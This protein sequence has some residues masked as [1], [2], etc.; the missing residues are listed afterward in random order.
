MN[1]NNLAVHILGFAALLGVV[2]VWS[3]WVIASRWGLLQSP[4][5]PMELMLLRFVFA[6]AV[7]I[8]VLLR[9]GLGGL[10]WKTCCLLGLTAG[11]GYTAFTY[12]GLLYAPA[13]HGSALTAGM[14]PLFTIALGV[15]MG[16]AKVTP[17]RLVGLCLMLLAVFAFFLDGRDPSRSEAWIGDLL[18]LGGPMMWSIYTVRVQALKVDAIRA[19]AIVAVFGCLQFLPVYFLFGDSQRLVEAG[20]FAVLYQGIF[21]G[22]IVVVGSL[23]LFT[24]AVR[25]LGSVVTTLA[26]STVPGIT[27]V[28]AVFLLSEPLTGASMVGVALDAAGLV[29]VAV[30]MARAAKLA[31]RKDQEI[32]ACQD[33]SVNELVSPEASE[34]IEIPTASIECSAISD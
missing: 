23:T 28:A 30:A 34:Q 13:A 17:I 26:T 2:C 25:S 12:T 8:P 20:P 4:L 21:H 19:T 24:Y 18:L 31:E 27:A 22:W 6:A 32:A 1:R 9:I 33:D 14:L 5:G 11:P 3:G 7:M 29:C 10:S 15:W 16:V